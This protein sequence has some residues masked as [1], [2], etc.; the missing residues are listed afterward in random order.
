MIENI[1]HDS[2]V[3]ADR[4]YE[5]YNTIA[6][7]E[8]NGLKYVIRIKTSGGIAQKFNIPHNEETDFTADIII[9]RRQT[10]EVKASKRVLYWR[11]DCRII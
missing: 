3:V 10:N 8:N 11:I 2:I 1:G 6:H 7:L 4:G 9:T 5:S